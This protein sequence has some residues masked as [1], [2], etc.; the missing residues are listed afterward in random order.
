VEIAKL[1]QA[2]SLKVQL[3]SH[4]VNQLETFTDSFVAP[5]AVSLQ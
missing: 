5:A 3:H 1:I 4:K 2:L